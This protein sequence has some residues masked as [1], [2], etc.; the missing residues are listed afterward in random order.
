MPSNVPFL[1]F[2]FKLTNQQHS[3]DCT[4]GALKIWS[5]LVLSQLSQCIVEIA[6]L[7]GIV[8][9]RYRPGAPCGAQL[10][11]TRLLRTFSSHSYSRVTVASVAV[12]GWRRREIRR[13]RFC[14][15]GRRLRNA[16]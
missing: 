6:V 8:E 3:G 16:F 2:Q 12:K 11:P 9:Y 4:I 15:A 13:A 10:G 5:C 7:L 1:I 14:S